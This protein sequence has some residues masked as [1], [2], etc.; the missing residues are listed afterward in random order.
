MTAWSVS[1]GGGANG[2]G[3]LCKL[4]LAGAESVLFSFPGSAEPPADPAPNSLIQDSDGN[5]FGTSSC[6]GANHAGTVFKINP[7]GEEI[8]VYS[9]NGPR[10][11]DLSAPDPKRAAPSAP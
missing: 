5:F 2:D 8:G 9:F 7:A 1:S 6:G 3:T 11:T 4:T 10:V